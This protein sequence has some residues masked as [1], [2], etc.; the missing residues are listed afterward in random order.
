M[1]V[2]VIV[3]QINITR[4]Q[5]NITNLDSIKIQTH[6]VDVRGAFIHPKPA[7][8]EWGGKRVDGS[9]VTATNYTIIENGKSIPIIMGEFHPQ[10]YPKSE[11]ETAILKIKAGGINTISAYFFWSLIEPTPN[12]F[13]FND[14]NDMR[15]FFMLCKKHGLKVVARIGPFCNA[16]FLAG[17]L[18]PWIYGMPYFERSNDTGYLAVVKRYY[19]KLA[20][21]MKGLYW[22]DGGPIYM[23]QLENE[24]GVAGQTWET[25]YRY[26]AND[27]VKGPEGQEWTNHYLHLRDIAMSV[28][29][30]PL[31]FSMTAWGKKYDKF[32]DGFL[33]M[34]GG[35][36]Y[37]GKP[38]KNNS[39]LN[40]FRKLDL[41]GT[42]PVG[43][44]ELGAAGTP[45]RI[46][47]TITPPVE[48][49][50]TTALTALGSIET[51]TLGYYMYHGGS[52]PISPKFGFMAKGNEYPMISYDFKAPISEFGET[53][54][55]YFALRPLNQFLLNY[56]EVLANAK[57]VDQ[58][59]KE[60][61]SDDPYLRIKARSD[62]NR[63]FLF[64]SYYG[65][66]N[67]FPTINSTINITTDKGNISIPRNGTISITNGHN[68]IFPYNL[69]LA[70]GVNLISATAQPTSIINY[71]NTEFR[72]FI[73]PN[74]QDAEFVFDADKV[75]SVS[76]DDKT[77]TVKDGVII[78]QIKPNRNSPISI[79]GSNGKTAKLLLLSIHDA[80]HS[81][82]TY[83]NGQKYVLISD[84]DMVSTKSTLTFTKCIKNEFTFWAFPQLKNASFNN[85]TIAS[86]STGFFAE[87]KAKVS[88]KTIQTDVQN[89]NTIK[90]LI[91]LPLSQFKDVND[92]YVTINFEGLVC[93]VFDI[94]Q[95]K[96]VAD[97]MGTPWRFSLGRFKQ[98]LAGE[99]L[100]VRA[101]PGAVKT[102]DAISEDG[103]TLEKISNGN[104]G[105][106][107]LSINF[108]PEYK[109]EIA[110]Q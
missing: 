85:I 94:T 99:G 87:Y 1:L 109:V 95:G 45:E 60:K 56:A 17:G 93:R 82:E 9:T 55:A 78:C 15:S 31:F 16:E 91:K 4:G 7:M 24:L 29:I 21:Q 57:C 64:T 61:N 42:V 83:V 18:P 96:M 11:W 107:I 108:E 6:S 62:Y 76:Y 100:L 102:K 26:G 34:Y 49:A 36:M 3:S 97:R 5:T 98:Q 90:S 77:F 73:S 32:P 67:A 35:Y 40:S 54:P 75:K 103:M 68:F 23:V 66:V 47:Y 80:E 43:F 81:M 69:L 38:G 53:R 72:F 37:L 28:G 50:T 106:K 52:N 8:K 20:E 10:R 39:G 71:N 86:N 27:E 65:N 41:V 89:I 44:C 51:L 104:V 14:Y 30:H 88:S 19:G 63:G 2:I 12:Q 110:I 84:E 22:Q 33:P 92:I 105:A 101:S 13:N 70:N 74:N 58:T 79:V 48:S 59:V 25:F 46:G